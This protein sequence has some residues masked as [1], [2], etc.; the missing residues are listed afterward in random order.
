MYQS[1]EQSKSLQAQFNEAPSAFPV[2]PRQVL[3]LNLLSPKG[4]INAMYVFANITELRHFI[5]LNQ[6]TRYEIWG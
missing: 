2:Q 3:K 1:N 6:L 4:K 5:E